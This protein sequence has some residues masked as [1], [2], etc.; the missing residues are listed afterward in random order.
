M[1]VPERGDPARRSLWR[2]LALLVLASAALWGS[3]QLAWFGTVEQ[4]PGGGTTVR[5]EN[6]AQHVPALL[7]LAVLALAGIAGVLA[8][9][10]LLRRAVG[11]LLA[12]AGAGALVA[13]VGQAGSSGFA[14]L[15]QQQADALRQAVDQEPFARGLA[16]LA[17]VLLLV[18]GALLVLR[19]HQM[20][21]LGARYRTPGAAKQTRDPDQQLWQA[22]DEGEDP[23]AQSL[24]ATE[25]TNKAVRTTPRQGHRQ[26]KG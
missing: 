4:R 11:V 7:P 24:T 8:T 6:G 3:S 10:G 5:V 1:R 15:P 16:G 9:A 2:V 13:A 19:G 20:P 22:L 12:L 14:G 21:R 18:A 25:V 17:G 23:T 26:F